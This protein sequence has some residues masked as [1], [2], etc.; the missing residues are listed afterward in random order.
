M[1]M[2]VTKLIISKRQVK[3]FWIF[4]QASYACISSNTY[5]SYSMIQLP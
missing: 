1:V 5:V 4:G 2:Y 3:Y